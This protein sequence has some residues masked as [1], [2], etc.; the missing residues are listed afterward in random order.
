MQ[1]FTKMHVLGFI[2]ENFKRI[3]LVDITPKKGVIEITGRN[4]QGKTSVL[5]ALW[6][7]LQGKKAAPEKP[8]RKGATQSKMTFTLG[9]AKTGKRQIIGVRTFNPDRTTTIELRNAEGT[10]FASPQTLLDELMGEL[11]FDPLA[12][13]HMETKQ[14]IAA[15][16]QASKLDYDFD[17]ANAANAEDFAARTV[18]N[19]DVT[20]MKAEVGAITVMEGLPKAKIDEAPITAALTNLSQVNLEARRVDNAKAALEDAWRNLQRETITQADALRISTNR[21]LDLEAQ[22]KAERETFAKYEQGR[23][24]AFEAERAAKTAW[25]TAPVGQFADA[26]ALTQQLQEAQTANREIDKRERKQRAQELLAAEEKKAA[27]LTRRVERR[28]EQKSAAIGKAKLPVDGLT[29][30]D[31]A[32]LMNGIP[33]EQLGEAEQ[34]RIS[35]LI[36]MSANPKLRVLRIMHGE[37]LDD[38]NLAT[39]AQL[40][41]EH[42]FQIWM[43]R[44]DSSGKVGIVMEDGEV[45][46]VNEEEEPA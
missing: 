13:I 6:G 16:R 20:R 14:Q 43:A 9:D 39:L 4:G 44:V 22:L 34:L 29:F 41:E 45:K 19:R 28:D 46:T 25:E 15:L 32:V 31:N 33:I 36:A 23:I 24:D 11:A 5:D 35:T 21:I 40:A 12:F 1:E 42:D 27:D 26:A 2:A 7:A 17:A 3:R 38:A 18:V 8:V 30:D 10:K 37:A